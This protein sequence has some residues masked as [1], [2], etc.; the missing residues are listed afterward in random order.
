MQMT[1]VYREWLESGPALHASDIDLGSWLRLASYVASLEVGQGEADIS[2]GV[3]ANCVGWTSRSWLKATGTDTEGVGGAVTAGLAEWHGEDLHVF[4]YDMRGQR[5]VEAKRANGK[6]GGRPAAKPK[7]KPPG[8]PTGLASDTPVGN[9]ADNLSTL[10]PSLPSSPAE[11]ERPPLPPA[12]STPSAW[13][14]SGNEEDPPSLYAY[15]LSGY[16][17]RHVEWSGSTA[18]TGAKFG[19]H[20]TVVCE[21]V[22]ANANHSHA[23][24]RGVMTLADQLLDGFFASK[25]GADNGYRVGWLAG[26]PAEFL[27]KAPK[28]QGASR[29]DV[30]KIIDAAEA[31]GDYDAEIAARKQLGEARP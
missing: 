26:N 28:A 21:W 8:K 30:Q 19:E 12:P 6:K 24:I 4:G 22:E 11:R 5:A 20:M 2:V 25:K 3:I 10:L 16:Q 27:P 18:A 17:R 9:Q 14:D 29:A 13:E 31:S 7:P 15:L 1:G 23:N